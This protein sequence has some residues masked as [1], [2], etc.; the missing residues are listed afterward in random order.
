MSAK[1][2][3]NTGK[4]PS[5]PAKRRTDWDAVERDYRTGKFT[6][7]E[8]E[9]KHGANNSLISRKAKA[10]GWTQDLA[11]AIRQ[12]TNARLDEEKVSKEVRSGAQKVSTVVL[13]VAEQN[14]KVILG[15]RT[16]LARLNEIKNKLLNQIE[17]AADNL[18]D[19]EEVIEMIR[20]P[21]DNGRDAVND[22]MRKAMSRSALV[23]DLKKLA[24][25][26]EKA[27]KGEREAFKIDAPAEKTPDEAAASRYTDAERAAKLLYLMNQAKGQ[28]AAQ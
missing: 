9:A 24:D 19:L 15:H 26:D 21:D 23:D 25:V 18:P 28:Q 12:A 17:Q 6:L 10:G 7:R 1:K 20:K 27:R 13:A 4:T 5:K 14:T 2:P 3:Q 16:G 11:D 22:A 8:L